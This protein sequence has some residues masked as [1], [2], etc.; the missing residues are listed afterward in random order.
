M[1]KHFLFALVI[2]REMKGKMCKKAPSKEEETLL[3]D[4][5]KRGEKSTFGNALSC[6]FTMKML[7]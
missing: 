2:F 5:K 3:G 7:V 4:M 6:V 1:R